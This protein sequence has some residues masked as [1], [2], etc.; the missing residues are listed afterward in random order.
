[1]DIFTTIDSLRTR[2]DAD[3]GAG[4]SIGFVPTMGFLHDGHV[5][6]IDAS[7]AANDRTVVS[8]FVN[9]LQFALGEDLE[10]YPRDLEADLSLVE[11]ARADYVF[12]PSIDEMYPSEVDTVVTVPG[13]AAPLEG[14]HRPTHFAGV[15]TVVAK[16]FSIVGACQAYFGA[17]DWQQVSVVRRM[18]ADLSM[19]VTVVPCPIVREADG[20]AMSSRN[21]YLTDAERAVAPALRAA[22]DAGL[23]L[24]TQGEREASAI[25]IEMRRVLAARAPSGTVD[26]SA[27]VPA[28]TLV[29]DGPLQGEVRLLLAVKFQKA[30]LIDNDGT[31]IADL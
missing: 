26:Y 19:P 31:V 23:V 16:L 20:L 6:L 9:P 18:V 1:M 27:A 12:A 25:E 22:L 7:V 8:I 28:H 5:S 4:R 17:K 10:D 11:A 14:V 24:L 29:S 21:V 13:V 15:A 30:R 2:L 3:R